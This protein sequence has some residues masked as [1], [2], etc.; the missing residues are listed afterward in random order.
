[1][2]FKELFPKFSFTTRVIFRWAFQ[3]SGVLHEPNRGF[4]IGGSRFADGFQGREADVGFRLAQ[5][6]PKGFIH[7]GVAA[8]RSRGAADELGSVFDVESRRKE[9]TKLV[10]LRFRQFDGAT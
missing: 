1:M 10:L 8:N 9:G 6:L 3:A 2:L 7:R 4:P 5:S